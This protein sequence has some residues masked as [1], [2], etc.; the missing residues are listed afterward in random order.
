MLFRD[1]NGQSHLAFVKDYAGR[2]IVLTDW[3]IFVYQPVPK[4]K[5]QYLNVGVLVFAVAMFLLTLLFWPLNAMLRSHY[6]YQSEVSQEYRRLR[7]W[8]RWICVVNLACIGGFA[9]WLMSVNDD[10]ALLSRH[11]DAKLHMLQVLGAFGLMGAVFSI[12]YCIRS[13]GEEQLWGWTRLWNT[14]LMLACLGYACFLLNWH[15]LNFRLNY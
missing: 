11:F 9:A 15:L 5:N 7:L 12:F 8:M 1:V 14:L 3:P 6:R 13:W 4:L 10:I 2:Q